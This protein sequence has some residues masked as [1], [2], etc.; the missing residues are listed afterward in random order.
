MQYPI[1][2]R[3]ILHILQEC[4]DL[5]IANYKFNKVCFRGEDDLRK[6]PFVKKEMGLF[7]A[8][9][10]YTGY[11]PQLAE[12]PSIFFPYVLARRTAQ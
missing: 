8:T 1:R 10:C 6:S 4:I 7:L 11:H 5:R 12:V 3:V 2:Y 9:I